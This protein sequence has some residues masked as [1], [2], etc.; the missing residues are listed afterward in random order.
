MKSIKSASRIGELQLIPTKC[1][2]EVGYEELDNDGNT[3]IT[4]GHSIIDAVSYWL[5][6]N[7]IHVPGWRGNP[8]RTFPATGTGPMFP[9]VFWRY[10]ASI[11]S[12]LADEKSGTL[13]KDLNDDLRILN[14]THSVKAT[15]IDDSQIEIQ[16]S[17]F[18]EPVPKQKDDFI[19]IADVG[20]GV[21]YSLPVVPTLR[22]A[23]PGQLVYIEQPEIHLHPKAQ[24]AMAQ[25]LVNAANRGVRVVIETHSSLLLL[26]VQ[27]LVAE[28][29]ISPDKIKLHWFTRNDKDG[30]TAI[31][32]GDLDEAG[33]FGDWPED[34]DD[35]A[36]QSQ[37]RY[38]DAASKQMFAHE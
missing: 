2:F 6:L 7:V 38:L 11:I 22:M 14:L 30:S 1:F 3:T 29:K 33:R 25:L 31:H 20:L 21:S 36:L 5:I 16:V 27:S 10:T 37:Q 19:S 17:R 23:K 35:V 8:E 4:E 9:G 34:F 15:A 12:A 26:G 18:K 32:S 24:V 13:L 28:G